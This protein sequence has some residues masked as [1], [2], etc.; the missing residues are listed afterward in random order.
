M[1][2]TIENVINAT[3]SNIDNLEFAFDWMILKYDNNRYECRYSETTFYPET[4]KNRIHNTQ[5]I[6]SAVAK[7]IIESPMYKKIMNIIHQNIT[8]WFNDHEIYTNIRVSFFGNSPEDIKNSSK[9]SKILPYV[10]PTKLEV[11]DLTK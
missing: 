11:I 1:R 4:T 3:E 2:A 7:K 5:D 10:D 9:F 8:K 6:A